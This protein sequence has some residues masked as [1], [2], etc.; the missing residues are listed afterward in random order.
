METKKNLFLI[1]IHMET[2]DIS[3]RNGSFHG[4]IIP[5]AYHGI[6]EAVPRPCYW[7]GRLPAD[8]WAG[9]I[10]ASFIWWKIMGGWEKDFVQ[11]KTAMNF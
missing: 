6:T 9:T 8:D 4:F 7:D 1:D 3:G 11:H 5:Q 10:C 2:Y